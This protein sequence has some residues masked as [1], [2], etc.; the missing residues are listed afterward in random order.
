MRS[1]LAGVVRVGRSLA[2]VLVAAA[3]VLVPVSASAS[4][5]APDA[6][7]PVWSASVSVAAHEGSFP[8]LSG[9]SRWARVGSLSVDRFEVEGVSYRVL[10]LVDHA[11]GLYLG[12]DRALPSDFALTVSGERFVASES[13]VPPLP[14]HGGYWWPLDS[15][16]WAVDD[17]VEVTLSMEGSG[18]VDGRASASPAAYFADVPERHEGT[19]P[20]ELRLYFDEPGL[21]VS[22]EM[23]RDHALEV[24]GGS[25]SDVRAATT[26]GNAWIV[27]VDPAGTGDVVVALPAAADCALA[28]AVCSVDGRML[29]N[30]SE[31]RIAGLSSDASLSF[32]DVGG[33]SLSPVFDPEV[34]LYTAEASVGTDSVTV[35]ALAGDPDAV[36]EFSPADADAGVGGHQVA[37][38]A[39]GQTAVTVTVTAADSSVRRYWT[40]I[41]VPADTVPDSRESE[42]PPQLSELQL[43]GLE[44]VEFTPE[45]TRY[46]VEA[47][48][49]VAETTVVLGLEEQGATIEVLT[50][51]GDDP[52]LVL[53]SADVDISAEGHQAQLS[54]TGDTLVVVRVTSAD[55]LRQK[56]YVVLVRGIGS[57]P[58]GAGGAPV[59]KNGAGIGLSSLL[60]SAGAQAPVPRVGVPTLSSLSVDG[61]TLDQPFAAATTDYTASVGADVSY[62]T[63]AATGASGAS[64]TITPNDADTGTGGHQ[65]ALVAGEPGGEATMTAIAVI[66]RATDGTLNA[67]TVTV[68]REAPPSNDATLSALSISDAT[69]SPTFDSVTTDYEAAVANATSQVTV[70]AT[71]TDD[72][73][74]AAITPSDADANTDGHQ[75]DLAEGRNT[76][77]VAVT[78]ANGT[79][80]STY[81]VEVLREAAA[82]NATLTALSLGG[83]ELS[84]AFA[85]GTHSYAATVDNS[86]A[87]VTLNL[88]TAHTSS[89]V[90][91]VPADNDPNTAGYQI[92]LAA[93][94]AGGTPAVT[95]VAII[96]TA[97]DTT[98]R[99]TYVVDITRTA[100]GVEDL[101]PNKCNLWATVDTIGT[102]FQSTSFQRKCQSI[103]QYKEY[104]NDPVGS[105]IRGWARFYGLRVVEDDSVVRIEMMGIGTSHHYLVRD[106]QGAVVAHVFYQVDN[107]YGASCEEYELGIPCSSES[108]LETTLDPG[109]YLV[110]LI[111]HY[112]TGRTPAAVDVNIE[113][114]Q[115]GADI[116]ADVTTSASVSPGAAT[117]GNIEI[118]GDR[119]WFR[120]ELDADFGYEINLR[121]TVPGNFRTLGD[122]YLYGVHDLNG[123]LIAGTQDDNSG[124]GSD[125]RIMFVPT[126]AGTY[127]ISV[128]GVGQNTGHYKLGVKSPSLDA[129]LPR[130]GSIA[131]DGT[132]IAGFLP[133]EHYHEAS[134][135]ADEVTIS[136]QAQDS[137][138]VTFE[139]ADSDPNIAGHQVELDHVDLTEVEITIT[140]SNLT[141]TQVYTVVLSRELPATTTTPA[142]VTVDGAPARSRVDSAGDRDWFAVELAA[143]VAYQIHM[144]GNSSSSGTLDDPYLY[145]VWSSDST[146]LAGTADDDGGT[147]TDSRVLFV[148]PA[149]GTY[150]IAA[151]AGA[152]GVGTYEISVA[153][154]PDDFPASTATAASTSVGGSSTSTD[155]EYVGDEDWVKIN[156]VASQ[157]YWIKIQGAATG[158]GTLADPDLVGMY[159]SEGDPILDTADSDGGLG[160]DAEST[161][162]P[163]ATGDYFISVG[164]GDGGTGTLS[165]T[166]S[167]VT[168]GF[169]DDFA[170]DTS[171]AGTI[172]V[173]GSASGNVQ[174]E[175]DQDWFAVSLQADQ[176]Y[177]ISL[178]G[179]ATSRGTLP[180]PYLHGVYDADGILIAN[181]TDDNSGFEKNSST[182][183]VA[184]ATATYYIAAGAVPGERGTYTLSVWNWSD[185]DNHPPDDLVDSNATSGSVR[186]GSSTTSTVSPPGD[187]DWHAVT[188]NGNWTYR[189]YLEG[190]DSAISILRD[191]RIVGIYRP[192]STL[193][194]DTDDNDGGVGKDA[195]V[196]FTTSAAGEHYIAVAGA[197]DQTGGYRLSV[198][199]VDIQIATAVSEPDGQDFPANTST[200]GRLPVDASV[201]G[202]IITDNDKDWYRATL[203]EGHIYRFELL[204]APSSAGTLHDPLLY[205]L[206]RADG[207]SI[208]EKPNLFVDHWFPEAEHVPVFNARGTVLLGYK[209][210]IDYRAPQSGIYYISAA[211]WYSLEIAAGETY[212]L[213]LD[214]ISGGRDDFSADTSTKGRIPVNGR[215]NAEINSVGDVDWF[216]ISLEAG[217]RYL[218]AVGTHPRIRGFYG[219]DGTSL[220]TEDVSSSSTGRHIFTAPNTALYYLAIGAEGRKKG[221]YQASLKDIT[222]DWSADDTTAGTVPVGTPSFGT[223]N[224]SSDED[225]FA[226]EV[227]AGKSY[228][229]T[230]VSFVTEVGTKSDPAAESDPY[231]NGIFDADGNAVQ[232]QSRSYYSPFGGVGRGGYGGRA[233]FTA[234]ATETYYIA[235]AGEWC[236]DL[237]GFGGYQLDVDHVD[238]DYVA[239]TSTTGAVAV[240]GSVTAT[241]NTAGD[242]DWFA[243]DLATDQEYRI[244]VEGRQT[245]Q[246]TLDDPHTAGVYDASG[247]LLATTVSNQD[248]AGQRVEAPLNSVMTY[249]ALTTGKHFIAVVGEDGDVGSYKL[250]IANVTNADEDD[251]GSS[252]SD[253]GT[254]EVNGGAAGNI[255]VDS[256]ADWFKVSFEDNHLYR[257]DLLGHRT[258]AG[259]L[260]GAEI[261]DIHKAGGG[262]SGVTDVEDPV[263]YWMTGGSG[264]AHGAARLTYTAKYDGTH[265]V[266]VGAKRHYNYSGTY[267]LLVTDLGEV[268][269]VPSRPTDDFA[270]SAETQGELTLGTAQE[271]KVDTPHERDWFKVD[272]EADVTYTIDVKGLATGVGTLRDPYLAGVFRDDSTYVAGTTSNDTHM[273]LLDSRLS[274]TPDADGTY[275]VSVGAADNGIGTYELTVTGSS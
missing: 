95:A 172:T 59:P 116:P 246:G 98:T 214:D 200:A 70:T 215:I 211:L 201:T 180:D 189:V 140:N 123:T 110:E 135:P 13:L 232:M 82:D 121:R 1:E 132:A 45:Q 63:V 28:F 88:A 134:S 97:A 158:S 83:I 138:V 272:L 198:E 159:D 35:D 210:R 165:L 237:R 72:G 12:I 66:V 127:Y 56:I 244:T 192:G 30:R 263:T 58:A 54:T 25:V 78:A 178:Q 141:L 147:G 258:G 53:D 125:S 262:A 117:F 171:T 256:E 268:S 74:D 136:A 139:P 260:G 113:I 37:L 208:I 271:G 223:I 4:D 196:V 85:A 3:A 156:L 240:D 257:I 11:E 64:V 41:S 126:V 129:A 146:R 230:A 191:P 133:D 259:S 216:A 76:I 100:T 148:A 137:Q 29:R 67:Y 57:A 102:F 50:A 114:G 77:T 238:D 119:D 188:L 145:G 242:V 264:K 187:I 174:Y 203:Q 207:S 130:L 39:G 6:A 161:F 92:P 27:T 87:E 10:V 247:A 17:V 224:S 152:S 243:V 65:I 225:W 33:L 107:P 163:T 20:L 212:T 115:L 62:V 235:I 227:E 252:V 44:P 5:G 195:S 205:G 273:S 80:M 104:Q 234:T 61:V 81:T 7:G 109:S 245:R 166:V 162:T 43:G 220:P 250:S 219:P 52:T 122:P 51:H 143:G 218:A 84:P 36:V 94:D 193:I 160:K 248:L 124:T 167:N 251:F 228:R 255:H 142:T 185:V 206:Y 106:A 202:R 150:Y 91:I 176:P 60:R 269:R 265:F 38:V 164:S 26:A 131:V 231:V 233:V 103:L 105:R 261:R 213:T 112:R 111:Q 49:D 21:D 34:T 32:L 9:Y 144:N 71:G 108:L 151:G 153:L 170:A 179:A 69:L 18:S 154:L 229:V 204:G 19:G 241:I 183:L 217:H 86:V 199:H 181:T 46:E 75:V 267:T 155:I 101:L 253:S 169:P 42:A 249:T 128:G 274:F 194:P 270:E 8:Q 120:V 79:D 31:A 2:A 226:F 209:Y 68:S 118:I 22:A 182:G 184:D 149:E 222:D 236:C 197:P 168:D 14:V 275:Y 40:L 190:H 93:P 24:T 173:G 96:V 73:A 47:K 186:V 254:I 99:Q 177:T 15:A 239:T 48:P 89:T 175:N 90:Q 266:S 16:L 157:T 55:G 23:L 221:S